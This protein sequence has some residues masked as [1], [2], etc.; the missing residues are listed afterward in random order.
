[1]ILNNFGKR[2]VNY[3]IDYASKVFSCK[4]MY[5]IAKDEAISIDIISFGE[6]YTALEAG[7][8]T[9]NLHSHGNNQLPHKLKY[10]IANKVGTIIVGNFYEIDLLNEIILSDKVQEIIL[11][12]SP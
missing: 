9:E 3:N 10:A 8:P 4:P 6:L 11:R 1:M 7:F 5:R 12:I 2:S